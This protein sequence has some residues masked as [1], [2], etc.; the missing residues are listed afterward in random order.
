MQ[1]KWEPMPNLWKIEN[2]ITDYEDITEEEAMKFIKECEQE[3]NKRT[4]IIRID[5]LEQTETLLKVEKTIDVLIG[6]GENFTQE[7]F[8]AVLE[9]IRQAILNGDSFIVPIEISD[10]DVETLLSNGLDVGTVIETHKDMRFKIR[11]I[12]LDNDSVAYA[13]FTNADAVKMGEDTST[14]VEKIE[15]FFDKIMKNPNVD[16]VLINPW[17]NSFWLSK[18][19]IKRIFEVLIPEDRQN[20][21]GFFAEV[22]EGVELD[23]TL[24]CLNVSEIG[25]GDILW[26]EL[27]KV[28]AN[29]YHIVSVPTFIADTDSS[30][31][32]IE[33]AL[34]TLSDWLHINGGYYMALCF[35]GDESTVSHYRTVWNGNVQAWNERKIIRENNGKLEDAIAYAMECHRGASAKG[36]NTPYILH[37]IEALQILTR[38]NADT[39]LLCA[40]ILHDTL[41]DTDATLLEIYRKFG[42]DVAA[43]VNAHT[44]DKRRCWYYRKLYTLTKLPEENIRVKMSAMADKLSNLR[45]L[46]ADYKE[47]GDEL[48]ERFNAPKE[49]QA[50]YY[51]GLIDAMYEM[52]N[53]PETKDMHWEMNDIYKDLFVRYYID[54]KEGFLYQ[55]DVS[56]EVHILKKGKPQWNVEEIQV[57]KT[58][59]R[60]HREY[61]ERVE[62][63]WND[64]FWE[65]HHYDIMDSQHTLYQADGRVIVLSSCKNTIVLTDNDASLVLD[66]ANTNRFLVQLRLKYSTRNKLATMLEKEFG[67]E[68]AVEKFKAFCEEIH[69]E[70]CVN[71]I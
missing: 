43:L 26:N 25:N 63:N 1:E 6:E 65:A 37:P 24:P 44:E 48:W 61:A 53:Y 51:S 56:G 33:T 14:A 5:S 36:T 70:V 10:E 29:D 69:V 20:L 58:A 50:W 18:S 28:R 31:E 47:I 71:C 7:S 15:K 49:M 41:E 3:N 55:V 32:A 45:R 67:G 13:A 12:S 8:V 62:D 19:N 34:H 16:G 59:E 11:T 9:S 21:I 27:E 38:M 54:E 57:P 35:I 52:Q 22:P 40:G 4:P 64:P 68:D 39:N 66:E 17:G 60:V 46:W 2:E 42:T 30:D 23:A